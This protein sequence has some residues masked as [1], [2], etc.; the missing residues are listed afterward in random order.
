MQVEYDLLL[1]N[2]LCLEDELYTSL[3]QLLKTLPEDVWKSHYDVIWCHWNQLKSALED[4]YADL[5]REGGE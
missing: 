3:Y 4:Y 5:E 1:D 2:I